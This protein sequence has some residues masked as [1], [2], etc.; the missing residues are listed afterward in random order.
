ML[1]LGYRW[2]YPHMAD[3]ITP[4]A[5]KADIADE[6]TPAAKK[7][8]RLGLSLPKPGPA[9]EAADEVAPEQRVAGQLRLQSVWQQAMPT[10][11]IISQR[12]EADVIGVFRRLQE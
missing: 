2:T 10:V 5:K 9:Q 4:A 12:S 11:Q 3:E 7:A 8:D 1:A 6:A